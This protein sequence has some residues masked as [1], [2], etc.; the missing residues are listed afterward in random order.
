MRRLI[1]NATLSVVYRA[2]GA[3]D[4]TLAGRRISLR[5]AGTGQR[6]KGSERNQ[7]WLKATEVALK[8]GAMALRGDSSSSSRRPRHVN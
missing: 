7:R 2:K 3:A 8:E 1:P 6:S 4:R 5:E